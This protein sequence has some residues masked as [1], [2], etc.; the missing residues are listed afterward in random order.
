MKMK[1]K[2]L[3]DNLKCYDEDADVIFEICD[4]IE[5]ECWTEDR[6]GVKTVYVNEKLEPSFISDIHDTCNI[7]LGVAKK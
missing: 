1:V 5:V 4:D 6:Y 3:M 7:E 2:D